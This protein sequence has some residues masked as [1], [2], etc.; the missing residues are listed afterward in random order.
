MSNSQS[1]A[2]RKSLEYGMTEGVKDF[3]DRLA[4]NYHLIFEDWDA[5]IERQAVTL[6]AILERECGARSGARILDCACGIG[7]QTLG[8]ASLGFKLTACDLSPSAV[9]RT[10]VEAKKRRLNVEL[11]VADMRDLTVIPDDDF[12]LVVCMDNALPHLESDEQLLQASTQIRKKLRAGATFVG[13][14][15]D[16]DSLVQERP[17]IQ[18]PAFYSDP[19]GRRIVHQ[20]WDWIDERRYVFH[21]YITREVQG[22]AWETQHYV[23]NYRA[24]LR[25]E[26]DHMF[27]LAEFTSCRWIFPG[28]S[29]FYQPIVL[30][31]AR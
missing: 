14:I 20:V 8:L 16:Y 13:S 15:R 2:F 7:T 29:G 1:S 28:E 6:G 26:L 9:E 5:S 31:K 27:H 4:H 12:D 3:Y 24:I 10:R 30:A 22:S 17:V 18:G 23:S 21:L 11:F 25:E 19:G